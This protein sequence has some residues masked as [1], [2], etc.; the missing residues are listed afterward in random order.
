MEALLASFFLKLSFFASGLGLILIGAVATSIILFWEWRW[1]FVSVLVVQTGVCILVMH[2]HGAP[3]DWAALQ[4]MVMGLCVLML[5]LSAQQTHTMMSKRR[6]GSLL[7]RSMAVLLLLASWQIFNLKLALPLISPTILPLFL[8][9]GLCTLV[10]LSLSDDAFFTGIA[11]LLWCIPV[12]AM[13]E[14]LLPMPQLFILINI[15]EIL[16]TLACSYLVL[17]GRAPVPEEQ[18]ITDLTFPVYTEMATPFNGYG[19]NGVNG[20]HT[21]SGPSPTRRALPPEPSTEY[22]FAVGESQ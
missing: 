7:L 12:Q 22:P 3:Q 19:E 8:W 20:D 18:V 17:T 6:P 1:A 16:I 15:L 10:L 11:L 13:I 21:L 9:L 2:V 14:I 5:A 4:I